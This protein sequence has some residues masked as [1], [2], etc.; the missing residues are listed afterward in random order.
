[1]INANCVCQLRNQ[2]LEKETDWRRRSIH[3]G[4]IGRLNSYTV[5]CKLHS[6]YNDKTVR[7]IWLEGREMVILNY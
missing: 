6:T 3:Q 2:F 5:L 7:C 4:M 1:M